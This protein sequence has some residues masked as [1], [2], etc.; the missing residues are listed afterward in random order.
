MVKSD[1]KVNPGV[2]PV[3][4]VPKSW[5]MM[6]SSVFPPKDT[7]SS[8]MAEYDTFGSALKSRS[9]PSDGNA[10]GNADSVASSVT[11]SAL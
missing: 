2:V 6:K 3:V 11:M 4:A 1:K 8:N 9:T 7:N 10:D 5:K